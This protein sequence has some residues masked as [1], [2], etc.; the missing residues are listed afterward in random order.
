VTAHP[1][2]CRTG[3]VIAVCAAIILAA[4]SPLVAGAGDFAFITTTD[5]ITGNSATV[6]VQPPYAVGCPLRALHSDAVARYFD[7]YIYVL[8]RKGADNVQ[9]LDP[10]SGFSTV[11]QFSVGTGADPHDIVVLSPTKAYVTRYETN[12]IWIVDPSAGAQT[13]SI[14]LSSL[15]DSDGL[16]EIDMMCRVGGRVF[17]T[18]QRLDRNNYWVPAGTSYVA[19][20]DTATDALVDA[21]PIEPGVQPITLTGT[22]PYS[23][24]QLD[25]YT[26]KLYV[27]CVGSWGVR[28]GGVESIDPV[29]LQS[30]G[31]IFL[32]TAAQGDMIDVE[33]DAGTKGFAIVM[34][35]NFY[36]LL[37]SFDAASGAKTG[38][39]YEPNDYV[40]QDIETSPWK[41]LFLADR[42]P[43]LPGIR[44]Y[45]VYSSAE[46]TTVPIDVCLPPFDI[47]F[48]LPVQTGIADPPG[49][50]PRSCL[51]QP[52]PN[53][54]NPA[55]TIPFALA[56][57]S[58]VR[59]TIYDA[60]GRRV[61]A[62]IDGERPDGPQAA[63]WDG[64]DAEGTPVASGVYFVEL[65]AG[66][67]VE[68]RKVIVTK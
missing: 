5:Y 46:V 48:S 63:T 66:G 14:D 29:T 3:S 8:N 57:P 26:G 64:R 22:D 18:V 24:I 68:S 19:V 51:G 37:V 27:S 32:E 40:L 12:T 43:T 60:L 45:D 2:R 9:I 36:T 13:G 15:A 35:D 30:D 49:A 21:D 65:D 11:R 59:L 55:T 34:D 6:G 17:V 1:A 16:A 41:E 39:L 54:F 38:T 44:I 67:V 42:T 56:R 53:P 33:I 10:E 50:G 20:I 28:D 23:D 58:R 52:Y 62:L 4:L 47:T 25:P 31:F 61:R 7:P